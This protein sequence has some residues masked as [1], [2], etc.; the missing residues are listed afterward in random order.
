MAFARRRTYNP[1]RKLA[2]EG[3]ASLTARFDELSY[4]GN[5]GHKRN[6]GDFGLTPPSAPRPKKSLCDDAGISRRREALDLLRAGARAGLVSQRKSVAGSWPQNIWAVTDDN[7]P[8]E[9]QL[10][11]P[12]LGVYHGYPMPPEDPF[13]EQVLRYWKCRNE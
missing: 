3:T 9:A 4:G 12:E 5:P 11:N 7:I 13:R 6:P 2:V 8:L 1:K 10:E